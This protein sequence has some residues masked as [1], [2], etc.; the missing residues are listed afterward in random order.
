[1]KLLTNARVDDAIRF[2]SEPEK[3]KDKEEIST[4]NQVF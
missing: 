1:M 2:V 3:S 4:T